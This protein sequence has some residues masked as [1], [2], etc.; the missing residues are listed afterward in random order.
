MEAKEFESL[1]AKF[2][3]VFASV[4][5][6]LRREI[7]AVIKDQPLTWEVA[8]LEIQNDTVNAKNILKFL[9]EIGVLTND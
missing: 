3:K 8:Y 4:P 9:K 5:M 6:P 2:V 1:K 7:I